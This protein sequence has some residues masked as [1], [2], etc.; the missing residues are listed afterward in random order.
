VEGA[1]DGVAATGADGGDEIGTNPAGA[2]SGANLRD[3]DGTGADLGAG[4]GEA[5]GAWAEMRVR[6]AMRKA[7]IGR[8]REEIAIS[9]LA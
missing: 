4:I 2:D 6:D 8:W 1:S 3:G 5:P 9:E 7:K